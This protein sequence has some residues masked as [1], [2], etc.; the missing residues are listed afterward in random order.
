M[1]TRAART[2]RRPTRR[3]SPT[4]R[5][6]WV[7]LRHSGIHGRGAF[8]R[9]DIPAGTRIIEYT[10]ERISNA[11]ADRR[12]DDAR[13]KRHHT[14]LFILS[15][16]TVVDGAVGG[17]Q[18][19]FINHSCDP[20]CETFVEGRHIYI[21]ALH[22]IRAGDELAYDYRYD[23][24]SKYTVDDLAFYHCECGTTNCRG[25]MVMVPKRKRHLLRQ[26]RSRKIRRV[27]PGQ[28][29]RSAA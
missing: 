19:R 23:W 20:N 21:Y 17:N 16:R 3:R 13:M 4:K 9:R 26:L 14:F 1:A 18:S 7:V 5:N 2:A 6:P 8:A 10:G 29:Q 25:T 12:Y 28:R 24:M 22:D 27:Q 15:S 11:E